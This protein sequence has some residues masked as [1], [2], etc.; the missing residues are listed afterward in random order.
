MSE[1][2]RQVKIQR[3]CWI[4]GFY[5]AGKTTLALSLANGLI[6]SGNFRYVALNVPLNIDIPVTVTTDAKQVTGLRDAVLIM[7]EAGQYLDWGADAKSL[8]KW[9][10]YLR[11][12][13]QVVLMPS[14]IPPLKYASQFTAQRLFNGPSM[15]VPVWVYRWELSVYSI[16]DKG[17]YWW[18]MP[19]SIFG[20]V[21]TDYEPNEEW[22]IYDFGNEAESESGNESQIELAESNSDTAYAVPD[23]PNHS[24]GRGR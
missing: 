23:W 8:K 3:F 5:G 15:G 16:K 22:F 4:R 7:D 6:E 12:R 10:Q 2:L 11:K 13:N 20:L 17:L 24:G 1:F 18:W 14:V 19:E 21:D 9:F